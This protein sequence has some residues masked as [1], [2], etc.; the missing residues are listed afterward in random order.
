MRAVK[1]RGRLEVDQD[2][3][4]AIV[5]PR[6]GWVQADA[7]VTCNAYRARLH[8]WQLLSDAAVRADDDHG[9]DVELVVGPGRSR[10][11]RKRVLAR[12]S[13]PRPRG[14]SFVY[15]LQWSPIGTLA[16]GYPRL[17]ARLVIT[18]I[19]DTT[20]LLSL[21]GAYRP[22]FGSVGH[23]ADEVALHRLASSTATA[24]TTRLA[25][26]AAAGVATGRAT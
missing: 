9:L 5:S 18:A 21:A 12:L 13:N 11:L 26:L 1:A 17:D 4:P 15:D 25:A 19:D 16:A 14:P 24:L 20:C 2:S 22:P 23:A 8:L 3:L 10:S 6:R 7:I